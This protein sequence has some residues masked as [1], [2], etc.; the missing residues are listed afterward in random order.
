MKQ[1]K[2]AATHD[3]IKKCL[4]N[5][6]KDIGPGGWDPH[7]GYG[8]VQGKAAFD[9]VRKPVVDIRKILKDRWTIKQLDELTHPWS[10]RFTITVLDKITVPSKDRFTLPSIDKI[11]A[12]I[13]DRRGTAKAID[14]V[15]TPRLDKNP[16]SDRIGTPIPGRIPPVHGAGAAPFVLSTPHHAAGAQEIDEG[17]G[18]RAGMEA[19]AEQYVTS[20]AEIE[21]ALADLDSAAEEAASR[22][23]EADSELAE[24]T[25]SYDTLVAQYQQMASEF[26]ELAAEI[27]RYGN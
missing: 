20:M 2:P 26:T 17:L 21:Q 6:A 11:T 27:E 19:I 15:K 9:C 22:A 23:V 14:D 25:A 3:D 10:D 18:D 5:T 12:T 1:G 8:I 24:I 16:I 4:Q 7:S 13:L